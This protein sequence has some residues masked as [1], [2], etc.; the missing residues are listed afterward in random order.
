MGQQI[1]K[2]PN[3]LL[4]YWS[5]VTDSINGFDFTAEDYIQQEAERQAFDQAVRTYQTVMQLEAGKRPYHQFTMDWDEAAH[6]TCD[7]GECARCEGKETR[8]ADT[9]RWID[10]IEKGQ[11]AGGKEL[12]EAEFLEIRQAPLNVEVYGVYLA[13]KLVGYVAK[14]S[15][16]EGWHWE[17]AEGRYDGS[18]SK[19][20]TL[21]A[22]LE[23]VLPDVD[24]AIIKK[25][26]PE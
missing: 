18:I 13:G 11:S 8:D 17:T 5:T 24:P 9:L 23:S 4:C 3:G 12:D 15:F 20:L 6:P 16:A 14:H 10:N 19:G 1:I 21:Q 22:A 7:C 25:A 26:I 2:Q